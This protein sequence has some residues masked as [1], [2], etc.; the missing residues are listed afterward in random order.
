MS[1]V[2]DVCRPPG[3]S[4]GWRD[5]RQ[6]GGGVLL[7][8]MSAPPPCAA[9]RLPEPVEAVEPRRFTQSVGVSPVT[10]SGA[11][12]CS[13]GSRGLGPPSV[14]R[15]PLPSPRP[16]RGRRR[17]SPGGHVPASTCRYRALAEGA[18]AWPARR[19]PPGCTPRRRAR[20]FTAVIPA[21]TRERRLSSGQGTEP[22]PPFR[23][24]RIIVAAESVGHAADPPL[25]VTVCPLALRYATQPPEWGVRSIHI[26]FLPASLSGSR[27]RERGIALRAI[28]RYPS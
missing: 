17:R 22:R 2:G 19:Q 9:P 21:P 11:G 28:R 12:R 26:A 18:P 25:A 23:L 16:S 27:G 20:L 4:L 1:L 6:R 13:R 10:A 8:V 5:R 3:R 7:M 14:A 15:G 24:R